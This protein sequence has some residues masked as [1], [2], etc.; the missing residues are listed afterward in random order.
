MKEKKKEK[1]HLRDKKKVISLV[2]V[3]KSYTTKSKIIN[4]LSQKVK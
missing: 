3:N 1:V 4:V 2:N